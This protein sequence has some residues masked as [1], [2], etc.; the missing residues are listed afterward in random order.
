MR[1][2]IAALC[3]I[4]GSGTTVCSAQ[5]APENAPAAGPAGQPG[6]TKVYCSGFLKDTKVPDDAR[7][8][9]GEQIGYKA[10]FSQG[11]RV[12]LNQGSDKGV[13][14]GDRFMVVRATQDPSTEW[15]RGQFKLTKA[16]G[17]LYEDLGQL[18]VVNVLPKTSIAEVTFSCDYM[19]RGDIVR[20]FEERP[21]PP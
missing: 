17:I 3:L 4:L 11:E 20:P 14:V 18:K 7:L 9:S 21:V 2:K 19:Q 1:A 5:T 8:V 15:F 10:V 6:Y 16:I 13:R 12:Y